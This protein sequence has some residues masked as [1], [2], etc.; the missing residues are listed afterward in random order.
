M[1]LFTVYGNTA[2]VLVGEVY[3]TV[4]VALVV[5]E[6][7]AR[8]VVGKYFVYFRLVLDCHRY[9]CRTG[10]NC[11]YFAVFVYGKHR[12]VGRSKRDFGTGRLDVVQNCTGHFADFYFLHLGAAH[13]KF[14]LASRRIVGL[15]GTTRQNK[16]DYENKRNNTKKTFFHRNSP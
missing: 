13:V 6:E 1:C 4:V 5:L 16:Q 15:I 10:R 3:A 9:G 7:V 8:H 2:V 14:V 11:R 12:R